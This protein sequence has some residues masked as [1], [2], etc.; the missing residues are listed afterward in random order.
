[1][2]KESS[3]NLFGVFHKV[4]KLQSFEGINCDINIFIDF[5]EKHPF[6]DFYDIF[7]QF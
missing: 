4:M 6:T 2:E 1:M 7:G 3:I 5:M